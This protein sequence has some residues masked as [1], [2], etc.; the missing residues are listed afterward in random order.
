[1]AADSSVWFAEP[2]DDSLPF[3]RVEVYR[4][5]PLGRGAYG[6]VYRAKGD[7]LPCAAKLIHS[8]FFE[9][10]DPGLNELVRKF[11]EECKL[12]SSLVHPNV[13][14]FLGVAFLNNHGLTKIPVM[15][16][17]IMD[18][19]LMKF[20][21]RSRH[22]ETTPPYHV[23]VDI[24]YDV[25]LAL[26]YLHSRNILHRDL[27]SNNVL[28]N[29][30]VKAKVSDFGVA[31]F[32]DLQ[33]HYSSSR[34]LTNCPGTPVFMPPE[35]NRTPPKYT[36][37]LD[38]FSWGVVCIHLLSLQDPSP[39]PDMIQAIDSSGQDVL[40]LVSEKQ[41]RES[42]ISSISHD[43]LLLPIALQ[44]IADKARDRPTAHKL[45]EFLESFKPSE[46][47]QQ[48]QERLSQEEGQILAQEEI[49]KKLTID[50]KVKDGKIH[51]LCEKES[52]QALD[53]ERLELLLANSTATDS[54]GSSESK[55]VSSLQSKIK[56]LEIESRKLLTDSRHKESEIT[57][58]QIEVDNLSSTLSS[59]SAHSPPEVEVSSGR[60]QAYALNKTSSPKLKWKT[61]STAPCH[62][63][64]GS[65]AVVGTKV[66][67]S[68]RFSA[69]VHVFD[70]SSRIWSIIPTCPKE[71]FSLCVIDGL[72]AAVGGVNLNTGKGIKS[73][74]C[75]DVIFRGERW[76]DKLVR[77]MYHPRIHPGVVS[78]EHYVIVAGGRERMHGKPIDTIEILDV[79]HKQWYSAYCLPVP[80]ASPSVAMC[81]ELI[82]V[83]GGTS[84]KG[85]SDLVYRCSF[86]LL[87][88]WSSKL[89]T[90][91]SVRKVWQSTQSSAPVYLPVGISLNSSLA[92][93]GGFVSEENLGSSGYSD[94]MFVYDKYDK[95]EFT[96]ASTLPNAHGDCIATVV[97]GKLL[98]IGGAGTMAVLESSDCRWL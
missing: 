89:V 27:S 14:Q 77:E 18:E 85:P 78:S 63:V 91:I 72:L 97:G 47:Y 6:A 98:V 48:S 94:S 25:A 34:L 19:S 88:Q 75:L 71:D 39:G 79:L 44:C 7:D 5:K 59:I 31:K 56:A 33:A 57:S 21:E 54:D 16:T 11:T 83:V 74:H 52:Q 50:V 65:A 61:I 55:V 45:C 62:F 20:I 80:L 15:I 2:Q 4:N 93:V 26:S 76:D 30:G 36:D 38:V 22:S 60:T 23:Q 46:V 35:A 13:V 70:S 73:V 17:E 9:Y 90:P 43:N 28:L 69:V 29:M 24:M 96:V 84:S 41:R 81:G 42:E 10:Q 82:Y 12:L 92:L 49:I 1:M 32:H 87:Y 58:L 53:I 67:L 64:R 51:A 40:R 3:T 8:V 66:Y 37:K 68:R 95:D 86:A